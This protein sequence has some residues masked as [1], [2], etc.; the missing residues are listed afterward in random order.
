MAEQTPIAGR[1]DWTPP[2]EQ[3]IPHPTYAP[4]TMALGAAF[5]FFGIVTSWLFCAAG[6]ALIVVSLKSWIGGLANGE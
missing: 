5:V 6:A 3:R 4:A 2:P 1:E